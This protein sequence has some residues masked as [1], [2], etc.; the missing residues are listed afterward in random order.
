M[1]N[2]EA[3]GITGESFKEVWM[4]PVLK[5]EHERREAEFRASLPKGASPMPTFVFRPPWT[6]IGQAPTEQNLDHEAY[7]ASA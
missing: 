5:A 3:G 2:V 1:P 6:S 7:G 4:G